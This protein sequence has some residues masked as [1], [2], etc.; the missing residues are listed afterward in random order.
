MT[1]AKVECVCYDAFP[2]WKATNARRHTIFIL[3]FGVIL[4]ISDAMTG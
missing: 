4:T 1:A 2:L 3:L